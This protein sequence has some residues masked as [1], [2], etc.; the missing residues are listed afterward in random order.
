MS[1]FLLCSGPLA[2]HPYKIKET[3]LF[4]YSAEELSYYIY[5]N[6]YLIEEDFISQE[7]LAFLEQE[8]KLFESAGRLRKLLEEKSSL[9][10]MLLFLLREF[11]YYTETE[12][13]EFQLKYDAYRHNGAAN[14]KVMKADFLLEHGHFL[15]AIHIYHQFD[16][17]RK[18]I[19]LSQDFYMKVKQHMAIGYIRLGLYEEAM[20]AFL[21]AWEQLQQEALLKQMY[22]FSCMSG[23]NLPLEVY[24]Q[25]SPEQE[26]EW[27]AEYEEC[28]S[29]GTLIATTGPTVA[30]FTKDSVRR[31]ESLEKHIEG[32]KKEYRTAI[33]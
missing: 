11:H 5:H 6:F 21:L 4:I 24:Q 26:S 15:S 2:E 32:I 7:L 19:T 12:I 16:H 18:D 25:I 33:S 20:E 23:I 14:R 30:L 3:G 13:K 29:S 17:A 9:S 27:K 22:Q 10:V 28:L 8:L 31:K 1:G